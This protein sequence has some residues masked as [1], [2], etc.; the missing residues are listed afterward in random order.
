MVGDSKLEAMYK[1]CRSGVL[2]PS[3]GGAMSPTPVV[4]PSLHRLSLI[5]VVLQRIFCRT[6]GACVMAKNCNNGAR[7][8]ASVTGG[9]DVLMFRLEE[10]GMQQ[11]LVDAPRVSK[12]KMGT[13]F[14]GRGLCERVLYRQRGNTP[15]SAGAQGI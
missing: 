2:D 12:D 4:A 6:N 9:E 8:R 5:V 7:K 14:D 1:G 10:Q 15:H 3:L 13:T 11:L